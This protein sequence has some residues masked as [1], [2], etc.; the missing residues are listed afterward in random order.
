MHFLELN[1]PLNLF[2]FLLIVKPLNYLV[3]PKVRNDYLGPANRKKI[4]E[5][6]CK[7][8]VFIWS[9]VIGCRV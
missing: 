2:F 5:V 3:E 8:N 4:L 6:Q 7:D 9:L 1:V